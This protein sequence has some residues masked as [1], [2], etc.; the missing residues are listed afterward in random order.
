MDSWLV[1]NLI[2]LGVIGKVN[3][4]FISIENANYDFY[5]ALDASNGNLYAGGRVNNQIVQKTIA[6]IS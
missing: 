5:L 3:E 2:V 1:A 6:N 4:R